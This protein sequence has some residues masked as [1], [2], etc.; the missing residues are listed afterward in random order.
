MYKYMY[1][2]KEIDMDMDMDMNIS[3][4]MNINTNKNLKMTMYKVHEHL[5][6]PSRMFV[7][8]AEGA[9][10]VHKQDAPGVLFYE[11]EVRKHLFG[12]R[13]KCNTRKYRT[14]N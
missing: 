9:P 1:I 5:V 7:F 14:D 3:M 11:L 13:R 2:N 6:C 4:N 10:D 8:T 12:L